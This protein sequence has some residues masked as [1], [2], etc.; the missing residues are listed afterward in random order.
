MLG[1]GGAF[2]MARRLRGALG[3]AL[4]PAAIPKRWRF[5]PDIPVNAQGKRTSE[6][7]AALFEDERLIDVL[8][9]ETVSVADGRALVRFTLRPDL[10]WFQGHFPQVPVLPGVAQVHIAARLAEEIW[11]VQPGRFQINRMKFRKIMQPGETIDLT[12]SYD[13]GEAKLT[14][15]YERGG[16]AVSGGSIG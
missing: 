13:F 15:A 8:A 3:E 4:E 16:E 2:Q 9:P 11:A 12:L 10:R 5:V 6:A 1:D 7:L 14:F